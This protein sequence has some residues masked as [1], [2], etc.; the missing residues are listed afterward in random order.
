M[1]DYVI[2]ILH[3]V[4]ERQSEQEAEK[5]SPGPDPQD[6]RETLKVTFI[7]TTDP[8]SLWTA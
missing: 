2:V 5:L 7:I 6:T 1:K 3:F 8:P 4:I